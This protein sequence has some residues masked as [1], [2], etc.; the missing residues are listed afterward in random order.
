MRAEDSE[1]LSFFYE[2]EVSLN[3]SV[4]SI[5]D[6]INFKIYCSRKELK[7][8]NCNALKGSQCDILF[9]KG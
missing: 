7:Q 9:I 2:S 3:L 8:V 4:L 6:E 5:G 1:T